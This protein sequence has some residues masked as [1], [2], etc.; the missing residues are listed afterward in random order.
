MNNKYKELK[1]IENDI[2]S[3]VLQKHLQIEEEHNTR[4]FCIK[5]LRF[6]LKVCAQND[7]LL[8]RLDGQVINDY[9][10]NTNMCT[11]ELIKR[12]CVVIETNEKSNEINKKIDDKKIDNEK[13]SDDNVNDKGII[14]KQKMNDNNVNVTKCED[15]DVIKEEYTTKNLAINNHVTAV[16]DNP[17]KENNNN[18]HIE[19]DKNGGDE[20]ENV[21]THIN[22]DATKNESNLPTNIENHEKKNKDT[23]GNTKTIYYDIITTTNNNKIFEWQNENN[24]IDSYELLLDKIPKTIKIVIEFDNTKNLVK[25]SE[26]LQKLLNIHTTTRTNAIIEVWKYLRINKLIDN[27]NAVKCNG[28]LK[29]IFD[30]DTLDINNLTTALSLH[31][32]PLDLLS[33]NVPVKSYERIFDVILERDDLTDAPILYKDKN[34]NY[35]DRKIQ[36]VIDYIENTEERK[37]A[38][39]QYVNDPIMYIN[40]FFILDKCS[41]DFLMGNDNDGVFYDPVV[42]EELYNILKNDTL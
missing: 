36:N 15:D 40:K 28:L 25:L 16:K 32:Q 5:R 33:F 20:F 14:K 1:Q 37:E 4:L 19:L 26:P 7:N 18:T 17:N 9:K 3:L 11:S 21:K 38:L 39:I 6:F 31:F 34:I 2:D 35:L 30:C 12:L 23:N 41:I 27:H 29:D 22:Y 42:A 24:K 8:L 13:K 10:N